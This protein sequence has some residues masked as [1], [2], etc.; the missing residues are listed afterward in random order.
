MIG[1]S[2]NISYSPL[3]SGE[4][5]ELD[6]IK[7]AKKRKSYSS[8][9]ICCS[10]FLLLFI[11]LPI[12]LIFVINF[13]VI[14]HESDGEKLPYEK[15][16]EYDYKKDCVSCKPL[17]DLSTEAKMNSR[18]PSLICYY[19]YPPFLNN[20]TELYPENITCNLCTHIIIAFAS[21]SNCT[22]KLSDEMVKTIPNL[23][24]LKKC[25]NDLKIMISVGGASE[26]IGFTEMVVN[27]ASRK[28]FIGS[29]KSVLALYKFDGLDIDWE[30][31]V[32]VPEFNQ[33]YNS[34]HPIDR[35]NLSD[36]RQRQHFSQLLR[37]IR[38]EYIREKKDYIL[39]L[40]VAAPETI[41]NIAYDVEEINK[42]AD[43]VNLMAY[44]F[45]SYSKYTPFTGMNSPLFNKKDEHFYLST[46]NINY[47]AHLWVEKGMDRKKIMI[48][49]PTFGH[50]FALV[51][52]N[53]VYPGSPANGFGKSGDNG[54]IRCWEVCEMIA[55]NAKVLF[56]NETLSPYLI[57]GSDW[58]SYENMESMI[59]KSNFIKDNDFGG[60]MIFSL[61]ADDHLG[62]CSK[63]NRFYLTSFVRN[64]LIDG[65]KHDSVL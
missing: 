27:H 41:V 63:D 48:G 61:N 8:A 54:F 47:T 2:K 46:L 40:A 62:K 20:G 36:K 43:F 52:S 28:K 4:K 49:L 24:N 60:A 33:S 32:V 13:T 11:F 5:P 10:I 56:D 18:T 7:P 1:P 22:L 31:P 37:E 42:Y 30:F 64:T 51:N 35:N 55:D 44:D 16:E 53:N 34:S 19:N 14:E 58:I 23:M 59:H 26:Y 15:H 25:N 12:I 9:L 3:E 17:N 21:I 45:H 38:L 57:S 39:S 50:T 29:V 65:D 6:S